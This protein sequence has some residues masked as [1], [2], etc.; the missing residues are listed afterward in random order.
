[1]RDLM[2]LTLVMAWGC[3]DRGL[4]PIDTGDLMTPSM[5]LTDGPTV[6]EPTEPS[7]GLPPPADSGGGGG[8]GD[9]GFS[10]S[11]QPDSA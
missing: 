1:M 6:D 5:S 4:T 7:V 3:G 10:D 8:R 11:G 9:S 2:A